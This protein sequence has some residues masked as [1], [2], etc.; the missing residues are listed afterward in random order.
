MQKYGVSL[1]PDPASKS[2]TLRYQARGDEQPPAPPKPPMPQHEITRREAPACPVSEPTPAPT[3]TPAIQPSA[4][5]DHEVWLEESTSAAT[6]LP[7]VDRFQVGG[8]AAWRLGHEDPA[9]W[10]VIERWRQGAQ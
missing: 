8:V 7:L 9:M 4:M 3:P 2:A 6:R 5:Q 1:A 10:T